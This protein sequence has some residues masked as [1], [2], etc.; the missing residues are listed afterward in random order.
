LLMTARSLADL[1]VRSEDRQVLW[2]SLRERA[3]N[4]GRYQPQD[5]PEEV[6]DPGILLFLGAM[7]EI[8][9]KK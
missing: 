2:R 6:L 3:L 7:A 4:A 8:A 9:G 1:V 5:L